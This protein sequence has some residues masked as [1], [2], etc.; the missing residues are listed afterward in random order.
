MENTCE[1]IEEI[2]FTNNIKYYTYLLDAFGNHIAVINNNNKLYGV[3]A[4]NN[5]Q[6]GINTDTMYR[7]SFTS[8]PISLP[9]G[10]YPRFISCGQ[11]HTM[12]IM[13]N[14]TIYGCG[15]NAWKAIGLGLVSNAPVQTFTQL[16]SFSPV[17]NGIYP[18]QIS[19][20]GYATY[21]IMSDNSLYSCGSNL[22]GEQ[23][24]GII[25][26]HPS[27][28]TKVTTLPNNVYPIRVANGTYFTVVLMSDGSIYTYG[29]NNN[30]QL[31]Q[32][33][34]STYNMTPTKISL[35]VNKTPKYISCGAHWSFVLMTDNSLYGFGLNNHGQLGIRPTS[36]SVTTPTEITL[37]MPG[38]VGYDPTLVIKYITCS[39]YSSIFLMTNNSL[40]GC[41]Q[42]FRGELGL[43]NNTSTPILKPISVPLLSNEIINY[44]I[45]RGASSYIMTNLN[46]IYTAG[47]NSSGQLN[48]GTTENS[49]T[50]VKSLALPEGNPKI[51]SGNIYPVDPNI[52]STNITTT[53]STS[54]ILI[55]IESNSEG[56]FTYTFDTTG[57]IEVS[58]NG[59][60]FNILQAGGPVTVTATQAAT[61][62]Y[63][64]GTTTFTV[65]VNK[66]DPTIT[67]TSSN[68]IETYSNGG[69]IP[70][71]T[72]NS[73]G[74]FTYNFNMLGI[75]EVSSNGTSFNILQA[76]AV[77]VIATQAATTNYNSGTTI[78]TVTVNKSDPTITTTSSNIIQTYSNGGT[79]QIPISS[80]SS[81]TFTYTFDISGVIEVSSNGTSFN[82]LKAGGP[83]TV[84]AT[85]AATVNYKS[86]TT[87]FTVTVNKINPTITTTSSNII[88]TYSNGGTILIPTSSN[89]SGTFTY[90]FDTTGVIEVSSNGTSFNMLGAGGPVT[91]IATQA[92]TTNYNSGTI[93]FTV[94]VNKSDPTITTT[95]SDIT[96]IYSNGG[97]IPIPTSSNSS[98]TFTY[99]FDIS[100]VI[101]ASSNGTS[102]NILQAGGP[103]TV[104]AT[105]GATT[106]Y[107]SG[108]TTFTVTVNKSDPT[109]TTTSSNI[110]KMYNNNS[111]IPIPISSN[112][113]GTFTYIFDIL[114]IIEVSSDNTL[115]NMLGAGGPVTVI[116]TQ[117]A[118]TNYNSGTIILTVMI[119]PKL[120]CFKEDTK[121]LTNRGYI[122]IQHLQKDDLIKTLSHEYKKIH[123]INKKEI[124]HT[125][126]IERVPDQLYE[127]SI[128]KY[129]ELFEPLILT[130]RHSILVDQFKDKQQSYDT[131]S[132]FG[133]LYITN[134]KYRLP[135]CVDDR[136]TIYNV[137]GTYTIY[138][139]SL[140]NENQ[141]T[142][143]G[144]YANGLLIESCSKQHIQNI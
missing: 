104:T 22:Q 23:G 129:P 142:N 42:N 89:S 13:S 16:T 44:I 99:T 47:I 93:I 32:G 57:V 60:S 115:F 29:Q 117:A 106:N 3:G 132:L 139:I 36:A 118:T 65:T 94:T 137:P 88:Q 143:Y 84:T 136:T 133:K 82:M 39:F 71:P 24:Q 108:T 119:T 41:G 85:Q 28:L 126:N 9:T 35:P 109:I 74:T 102:F 45:S 134:N 72:S 31:G 17:L 6:L 75:I 125:I 10:V 49:H 110:T 20:S 100:G 81:G 5:Y 1:N 101:E 51:I 68:I 61:N 86:I 87:T 96:E 38:D 76:G 103:V 144:I 97:T 53:Y 15:L 123:K 140:E 112:S 59:T 78:F 11:E 54:P 127:C 131:K 64:S 114:G 7:S 135:A 138:H 33:T 56:T 122:P 55:P 121:I 27:M 58:S 52:T 73:S 26:T 21:V 48:L 92:A 107:N 79:I 18:I 62:N 12:I 37:L 46:N 105:Q 98:G 43:N 25:T 34:I 141:Y 95:S 63:N 120:F 80:N 30:G 90:T 91:V 40:Y 8:L 116:A 14:N 4:N 19:C 77:T 50:F 124:I 66:S 128:D 113:N 69:T 130:G 67:T 2:Y 111:T 83:V 70:I